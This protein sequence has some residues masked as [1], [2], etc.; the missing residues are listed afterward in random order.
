MTL[1]QI[2]EKAER[3]GRS[4]GLAVGT[5]NRTLTNFAM[6]VKRADDEGLPVH[7]KLKPTALRRKKTKRSRAD[8]LA[9]T[10]DHI[11]SIFQAPV[12]HGCH[13]V[14]R[15]HKPG[16]HILRDGLYWLPLVAAYTGARREEIAGLDAADLRQVDDIW[17]ADITSAVDVLD[18]DTAAEGNAVN[19]ALARR[20]FECARRPEEEWVDPEMVY[21]EGVLV[22][23]QEVR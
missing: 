15:R 10:P 3:E 1:E 11:R 16:N 20:A 17:Q 12:W 9:F 13:N 23:L 8:R 19:L 21:A 2:A 22:R 14:A 7:P 4:D 18:P 5:V 6:L